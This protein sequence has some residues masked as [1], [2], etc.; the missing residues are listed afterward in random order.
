MTRLPK[1]PYCDTCAKAKVQRKQ[2][3]KNVAVLEPDGAPKRAPVKFGDQV[4]GCH[5]IKNDWTQN[6][7]EDDETPLQTPSR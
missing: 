4:T 6:D 7:E 2:T 1:T 5:F 3:R